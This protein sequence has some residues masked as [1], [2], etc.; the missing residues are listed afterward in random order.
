MAQKET[1]QPA[2]SDPVWVGPELPSFS[3]IIVGTFLFVTGGML[4]LTV[5]GTP[6]G[7]VLFAVGIGMLTTPK[8]KR[9]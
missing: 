2:T 8:E 4:L 1:V 3:A 9:R 6:L 5:I 7:I